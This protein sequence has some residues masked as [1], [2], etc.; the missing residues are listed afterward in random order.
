MRTIQDDVQQ[1]PSVGCLQSTQDRFPT[2]ANSAGL[3]GT[4]GKKRPQIFIR[5]IQ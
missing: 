1:L 5:P 3:V 4:I 2:V